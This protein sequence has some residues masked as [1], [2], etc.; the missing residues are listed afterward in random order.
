MQKYCLFLFFLFVSVTASTQSLCSIIG[1][2]LIDLQS[3]TCAVQFLSNELRTDAIFA[4]TNSKL[5]YLSAVFKPYINQ[6]NGKYKAWSYEDLAFFC[7]IEVKL[8][9]AVKMPI[10]FR[11]GE[12]QEVERMEGKY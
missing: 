3:D 5:P 4:T 10:K 8:E 6:Q 12:V 9:K 11:L 1:K 2:P 7:K